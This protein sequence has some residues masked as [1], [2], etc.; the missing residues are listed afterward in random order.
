MI[1]IQSYPRLHVSLF[2]L[3]GATGRKYGGAGFAIDGL[4]IQLSVTTVEKSDIIVEKDEAVIRREIEAALSR[5]SMYVKRELPVS[6]HVSGPLRR[7]LGLGSKTALL[8][9]VLQGVNDEL[10]LGL[11]PAELQILSGRGGTSGVGVNSFFSGGFIIDGGHPQ[12]HSTI[13]EP[14]SRSKGFT[15]P[16]LMYGCPIPPNW[17]FHLFDLSDGVRRYEADEQGFFS[18]NAPV[19]PA[20]VFEV[21]AIAYQTLGPAVRDAD[22]L[23]LRTGISRISD[24][25]FKSREIRGQSES[26]RALIAALGVYPSCAVGM[27]SMGP[28]VYAVSSL[29]DGAFADYLEVIAGSVRFVY[30]GA[31]PG[32]N[33]GFG[34]VRE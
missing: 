28:L 31:F 32:R 25:G 16:P 15:I 27:S 22:L 10:E 14:S 29:G 9:G 34:E 2:D 19:P 24:L 8:L 7:H 11:T 6:I 18:S 4:P 13:F 3:A 12:D 17:R 33:T 1:V 5:T 26:V 20:E 30:L 23:L 21:I